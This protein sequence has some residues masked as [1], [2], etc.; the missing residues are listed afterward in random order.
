MLSSNSSS[1]ELPFRT[2]SSGLVRKMVLR[3]L[4]SLRMS[5]YLFPDRASRTFIQ[6]AQAARY[7][8]GLARNTL[9]RSSLPPLARE[10]PASMAAA[11]RSFVMRSGWKNTLPAKFRTWVLGLAS[12][13]RYRQAFHLSF[14]VDGT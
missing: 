12:M 11:T 10:T 7:K 3:L 1:Q 9:L 13:A 5:L 8:S 6:S 2:T 4:M 14:H